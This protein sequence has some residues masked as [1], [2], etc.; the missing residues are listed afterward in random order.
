MDSIVDDDNST[1]IGNETL[2][3]LY[4]LTGEDL[5]YK[6]PT[7]LL[8]TIED[9]DLKT[10]FNFE[11]DEF[12]KGRWPQM[13]DRALAKFQKVCSFRA[14]GCPTYNTRTANVFCRMR[15]KCGGEC[16]LKFVIT[17]RKKPK[18]GRPLECIVRSSGKF[19]LIQQKCTARPIKGFLRKNVRD[20]LKNRKSMA[21][22]IDNFN[23]LKGLRALHRNHHQ[24]NEDVLRKIKSESNTKR[25][26]HKDPDKQIILL[27]DKFRKEGTGTVLKG[28]IQE[29][30][31]VNGERK[32]EFYNQK[33]LRF[34]GEFLKMGNVT[35]FFDASWGIVKRIH[36]K[37]PLLYVLM[38]KGENGITY[39]IGEQL[40]EKGTNVDLLPF[41]EHL[42]Q[43]LKL[44]H[45]NLSTPFAH[46]VV[47]DWSY[48]LLN[49][50]CKGV[51]T[52]KLE[53]YLNMSWELLN[54]KEKAWKRDRS[55][56]FIC[57]NH[58]IKACERLSDKLSKQKEHKEVLF[59]ALE[60]IAR[61]Q[62]S[63]NMDEFSQICR[64]LIR[65]F[66]LPHRVPE[67]LDEDILVLK[68]RKS[69]TEIKMKNEPNPEPVLE[70]DVDQ[71]Q[72]LLRKKSP[73]FQH[74]RKLK[75]QQLLEGTE[76]ILHST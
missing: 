69:E 76:I 47:V 64:V 51:N 49:A 74:Y 16:E 71:D 37:M 32:V 63:F 68:S 39:P 1:G 75:D 28:F 46:M 50:V 72:V 45:R 24:M 9:D 22:F 58:L 52:Q 15:G 43:N 73:F 54:G 48:A 3:D 27:R 10:C 26:L 30:N 57:K 25:R 41:F 12:I 20:L 23:E 29:I 42:K 2:K 60:A 61:L 44:I 34:H 65:T 8:I 11:T 53:D 36:E 35:V 33:S 7:K 40:M 66:G 55:C 4:N 13:I 6:P 17:V 56:V 59:V 62:E 5:N 19:Q 18:R 21:M 31:N 70:F 14:S 67:R 38:A